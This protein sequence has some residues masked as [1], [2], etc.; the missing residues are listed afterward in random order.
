MTAPKERWYGWTMLAVASVALVATSPGQT[1]I[2]SL[3]NLPMRREL[4]LSATELSGAYMGATLGSASLMSWVGKRSDTL[5]PG[6]LMLFAALGLALATLWMSQV[7][8]LWMLVLGF[9][10]I[11]VFGQGALGLASGHTLAMWFHRRLGVAEGVRLTLFGLAMAT[12]PGLA[13]LSIDQLGWRTTWPLL[14]VTAGLMVV[15]LVL[16]VHRDRPEDVGQT[17]DGD[18]IPEPEDGDGAPEVWGLT[19]KEATRTPA[20]WAVVLA[21]MNSAMIGT[22]LLFH[23]QPLAVSV[24]M[25][26]AAAASLIGTF[27]LVSTS[28]FFVAGGL[29]D[30]VRPGFIFAAVAALI[31]GSC[32]LHAQATSPELL[33]LAWGMFGVSSAL[34]MTTASPT[35]AR[36]FGR[37]HHGA[38]RGLVTTTSVAGTAVGP[39]ILGL[40]EDLTG[41]FD[42]GLLGCAAFAS[43][44]GIFAL[45]ARIEPPEGDGAT[46]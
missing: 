23:V 27:A 4:G 34:Q 18:P 39:V 6:R 42:A 20:F 7:S 46:E 14:G 30:R 2:V 24:G 3:F 32:L 19:L 44:V 33:Y 16:T 15:G 5:G 36:C 22:A 29:S 41:S 28:L 45:T 31:A 21:S 26:E 37:A 10:G 17:L 38:I 40:S 43:A 1:Y 8:A 35:L 13:T 11:R 9:F 25:D 12:L